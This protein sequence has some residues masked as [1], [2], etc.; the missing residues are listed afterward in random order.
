MPPSVTESAVV[1]AKLADSE[2]PAC[3]MCSHPSAFHD[4][5]AT[6]YCAASASAALSRSCVCKVPPA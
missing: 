1:T 2:S 6:R 4:A 5:I 3:D